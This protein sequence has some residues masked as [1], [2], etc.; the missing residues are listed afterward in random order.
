MEEK[1]PLDFGGSNDR[2]ISSTNVHRLLAYLLILLNFV[3]SL[4][5]CSA[6]AS[7]ES[8]KYGI[9]T[10]TVNVRRRSSLRAMRHTWH[11]V[12]SLLGCLGK[13]HTRMSPSVWENEV[14]GW[15]RTLDVAPAPAFPPPANPLKL[16]H[17]LSRA[18]EW[19]AA[20]EKLAS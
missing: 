17:A 7:T 10:P 16:T 20:P 2:P 19:L 3:H 8:W 9:A 14:G 15:G 11:R 6:F 4:D 12:T 1:I 18:I 5:A 13:N